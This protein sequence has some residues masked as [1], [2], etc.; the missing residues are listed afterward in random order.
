MTSFILT[1]K[2]SFVR[3]AIFF[4]ICFSFYWATNVMSVSPIY[5]TTL[6]GFITFLLALKYRKVPNTSFLIYAACVC[7]S[8]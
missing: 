2:T 8:L 5:F 6:L 4:L 1:R 7:Y 3:L